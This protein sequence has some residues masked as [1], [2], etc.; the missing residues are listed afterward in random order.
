MPPLKPIAVAP[1]RRGGRKAAPAAAASD[2][3]V[4][5][6]PTIARP[7]RRVHAVPTH[8][9]SVGEKLQMIGGGYSIAR[10]AAG[11][12]V[13]SL[14]PYEGRGALLYR[15]RSDTESFERVV[16]EADLTR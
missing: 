2:D 6:G 11:C 10:A 16:P 14:L 15:V 3:E 5:L 13:V 4:S 12:K 9:F 7:P 1:T 8:R